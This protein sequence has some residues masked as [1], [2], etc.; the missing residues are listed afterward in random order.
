MKPRAIEP[1][2]RLM[3]FLEGGNSPKARAKAQ[4]YF[5]EEWERSE[6]ERLNGP[7][8]SWIRRLLRRLTIIR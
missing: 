7:D 3:G 5:R 2:F 1:D 4:A 8:P 6:H